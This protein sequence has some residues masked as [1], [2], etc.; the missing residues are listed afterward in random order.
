[1]YKFKILPACLNAP[2]KCSQATDLKDPEILN[3]NYLFKSVQ[4]T[5]VLGILLSSL[6]SQKKSKG[7]F[8]QFLC[9]LNFGLCENSNPTFATMQ[10]ELYYTGLLYPLKNHWYYEDGERITAIQHILQ[11]SLKSSNDFT[12]KVSQLTDSVKTME[13]LN[14]NC[15]RMNEDSNIKPSSKEVLNIARNLRFIGPDL[16]KVALLHIAK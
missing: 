14:K 8:E 3:K 5:N 6:K 7:H 13:R 1:M 4:M 11:Q 12:K 2:E 9:D 15:R 10:K 16:N